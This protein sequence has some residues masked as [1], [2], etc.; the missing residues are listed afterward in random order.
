[1]THQKHRPGFTLVE[2]LVVMAIMVMLAALLVGLLPNAANSEREARAARLVQGWLNIAKQRAVRD[3]APR[4][5]RLFPGSNNPLWVGSAQYIE[6]PD[7]FTGGTL[8]TDPAQLPPNP[9]VPFDSVA[10]TLAGGSDLV[11]GQVFPPNSPSDM[12][13]WNVQPGDYLEIL[14]TGLVYDIVTVTSPSTIK[15][16]P[17]LTYPIT[18][19][20][21]YYRILR[22]PRVVGNDTLALP[23]GTVID[24]ATNVAYGNPLPPS[25]SAS[26]PGVIDILFS[27]SGAVI[28]RGASTATIN[29]WVR[30]PSENPTLVND[31]FQSYPTIVAIFTRTGLVGAYPPAVNNPGGPYVTI[32]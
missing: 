16:S 6:Q 30:A 1:M 8:Q 29:L 19:P 5:L 12:E 31:P 15:V 21:A 24:L 23:N 3:Q 17:A 27:P 20:T 13:L 26:T 32:H 10:F 14:G 28:T 25:A 11:N 18:T 4:G 7:D 2:L 9:P 22:R